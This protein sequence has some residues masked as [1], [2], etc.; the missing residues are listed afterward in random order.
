MGNLLNSSATDADPL[1]DKLDNG[2]R[3]PVKVYRNMARHESLD[4]LMLS[5]GVRDC[6]RYKNALKLFIRLLGSSKSVVPLY[7]RREIQTRNS[8]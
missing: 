1:D 5:M 2:S 4:T 3:S 8:S 6:I 7:L